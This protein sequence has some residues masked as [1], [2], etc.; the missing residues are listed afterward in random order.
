[1]K[2]Y[3]LIAALWLLGSYGVYRITQ[4]GYSSWWIV[5]YGLGSIALFAWLVA[6]ANRKA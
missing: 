1:M 4:L 3:L 5:A 6:R 2:L